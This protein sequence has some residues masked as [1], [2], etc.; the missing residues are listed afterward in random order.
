VRTKVIL[1]TLAGMLFCALFT[2]EL[3]E[4]LRLANDTSNDF[5][6]TTLQ[7]GAPAAT[8]APVHRADFGPLVVG[9]MPQRERQARVQ[10]RIT[11]RSV[12]DFLHSLC[13]LRT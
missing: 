4:L 9:A 6:M 11:E 3:P 8:K 13:T 7:H 2:M 1:A 12:D 5:S 10:T